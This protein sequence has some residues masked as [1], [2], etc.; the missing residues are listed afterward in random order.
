[1]RAKLGQGG[2]GNVYRVRTGR[3]SESENQIQEELALKICQCP[4]KRIFDMVRR[5]I[6]IMKL[7]LESPVTITVSDDNNTLLSAAPAAGPQTVDSAERS[8]RKSRV[9][10]LLRYEI[11]TEATVTNGIARR[12]PLL[13]ETG[14]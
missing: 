14:L 7:F 13:L 1:M 12:V 9:I 3:A 10:Q 4:D 11:I 8:A 5:E 2:F 6:A